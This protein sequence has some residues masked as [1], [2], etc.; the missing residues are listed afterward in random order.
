MK[1]CIMLCAMC[2]SLIGSTRAIAV[3]TLSFGAFDVSFY[4]TGDTDGY[5]TSSATW[6]MEQ[7]MDVGAGV[8]AW[9]LGIVNTP[10]RQVRMNVHWQDFTG[11]TLGSSASFRVANGTTM[12]NLGEYVWREGY[13]P[14]TTSLGFDTVVVYDTD[15]AGIGWNFGA[16]YG[17]G[18]D[19]RSVTAHEVGHSLGW[20]SGCAQTSDKFGL[21]GTDS[22]GLTAWDK[23]L[24]DSIGNKPVSGGLGIPDNFNETDNPIFWDGPAATGIY[25]SDVPIFAPEPFAQGS[26]LSHL[27]EGA[28][29]NLLMSPYLAAGQT[30]RTV[31]NLEWAMMDDMGWNI[32]IV[33]APGAFALA[34]IGFGSVG[35]LR[36]KRTL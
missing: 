3:S 8:Q 11:P 29:G 5:A 20:Q 25:A 35:W 24:V 4:N 9:S 12:W 32:V 31:S 13:D 26:S 15:A 36:K 22:V 34:G 28:F 30:N 14:G 10:G 27:D 1:R 2:M 17:A 7:M 21:F 23:N 16:G 19:F 18:I 6:T 33:P